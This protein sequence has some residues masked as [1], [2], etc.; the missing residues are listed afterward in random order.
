MVEPAA[1]VLKPSSS[2]KSVPRNCQ[3]PFTNKLISPHHDLTYNLPQYQSTHLLPAISKT[4][5]S[6]N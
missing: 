1:P 5:I 2:F 3:D 4:Q 6:S